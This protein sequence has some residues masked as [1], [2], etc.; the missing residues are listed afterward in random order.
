MTARCCVTANLVDI[1]SAYEY[2]NRLSALHDALDE[3]R[4]W[5]TGN[6]IGRWVASDLE[7]FG[8]LVSMEGDSL[9]LAAAE[10]MRLMVEQGVDPN[11]ADAV[12]M[13]HYWDATRDAVHDA[14]ETVGGLA[15]WCDTCHERYDPSSREGRCGDCGDCGECCK[16]VERVQ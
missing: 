3:V 10:V 14:V 8:E 2:V 15:G 12:R 16:H 9:T 11:R 4:A 7:V 1:A 6:G 13:D 5:A